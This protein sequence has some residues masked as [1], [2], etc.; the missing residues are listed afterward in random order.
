MKT[1]IWD[2][3][4]TIIDDLKISLKA[5]NQMLAERGLPHGY[6]EEDYRALFCF[7]MEDYYRKIGYTFEN[8]TFADVAEEFNEIYDDLFDECTL[9]KGVKDKLEEAKQKGYQNV[10][11]SSCQ[12]D[13]LHRQLKQLG[14]YDEFREIMGIDNLL[15]GS[16]IEIGKHWMIRSGVRPEECMYLGDT[17]ADLDTAKALNIENIILVASG[18]QS[19]TQLKNAWSQVVHDLTEVEL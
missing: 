15:G 13:K 2:Y 16:K 18:H 17:T 10:I 4:G 8:E 12:D 11:L 3:N 7:P 14:I 1:L 9:C 6:T 19:Y 5:E